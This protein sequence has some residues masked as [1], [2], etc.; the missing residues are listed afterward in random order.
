MD[1][2]GDR[3]AREGASE[4]AGG[5]QARLAG[6]GSA[7]GGAEGMAPRTFGLREAHQRCMRRGQEGSP[8]PCRT[9]LA[10]SMTG[11]EDTRMCL[12]TDT[13]EDRTLPGLVPC[14]VHRPYSDLDVR[15]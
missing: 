15:R 6:E 2:T 9:G 4:A 8:Q 10:D 7:T 5:M 12:D 13:P 3:P 11:A 1:A 14:S